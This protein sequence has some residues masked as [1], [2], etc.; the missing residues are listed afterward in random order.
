MV[1]ATKEPGSGRPT[2]KGLET[3]GGVDD[4][5]RRDPDGKYTRGKEDEEHDDWGDQEYAPRGVL[6]AVQKRLPVDIVRPGSGLH[7]K[8]APR[9]AV[10]QTL[11][12]FCG[13]LQGL[14][15]R[16]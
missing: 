9:A 15:F 2:Q 16:V 13:C 8:V 3:L 5:R 11:R 7:F 1:R 14:G 10:K 6:G 4:A 12:S